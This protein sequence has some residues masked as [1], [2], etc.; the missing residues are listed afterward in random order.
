[1]FLS[2]VL[3]YIRCELKLTALRRACSV[4]GDFVAWPL[5]GLA[6]PKDCYA[7]DTG[8]A[9]MGSSQQSGPTIT[10]LDLVDYYGSKPARSR[11]PGK[12]QMQLLSLAL[13]P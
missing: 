4:Q 13:C 5:S 12:S 6:S 7:M 10:I 1:M 3:R 11:Q 9:I 8:D 2:T